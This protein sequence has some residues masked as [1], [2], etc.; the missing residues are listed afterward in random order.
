[1]INKIRLLNHKWILTDFTDG[2]YWGELLISYTVNDLNNIEF[3]GRFPSKV[4]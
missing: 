1:M 2:K 4:R 3:E